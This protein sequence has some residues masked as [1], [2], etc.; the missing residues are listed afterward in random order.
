MKRETKIGISCAVCSAL[1]FGFTPVLAS[2]TFEMGSNALTLT[3]YRNTMAVPVLLVILLIR[4]ST[5]GSPAES[6][7]R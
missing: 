3:F 4:R 7:W 6:C 2:I 1:I 5:C